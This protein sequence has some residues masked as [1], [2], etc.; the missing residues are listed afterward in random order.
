MEVRIHAHTVAID[1]IEIA[2]MVGMG[3]R[4][5]D[6]DGVPGSPEGFQR[7]VKRLLACRVVEANVDDRS[8]QGRCRSSAPAGGYGEAARVRGR[9][10]GRSAGARRT[11][12]PQ[13]R[14]LGSRVRGSVLAP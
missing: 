12:V 1:P 9:A 14:Q 8:R 6:L 2:R 5:D 13:G 10:R 7:L 3:M 11:A 4:Q